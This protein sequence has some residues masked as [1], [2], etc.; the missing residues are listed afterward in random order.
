MGSV[1]VDRYLAQRMINKEIVFSFD[2]HQGENAFLGDRLYTSR[3]TSSQ[4][5]FSSRNP[6][7]NFGRWVKCRAALCRRKTRKHHDKVLTRGCVVTATCVD[8]S[9][10]L[11]M[12][13]SITTLT[14]RLT[15]QF[16]HGKVVV[17]I[18]YRVEL[19]AHQTSRDEKMSSLTGY[20]V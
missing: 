1:C 20:G 11:H 10:L 18:T 9:G 3:S 7:T 8:V 17:A 14:T 4:Q 2:W 16:P 12:G 5:M 15:G 19:T 6:L 13:L